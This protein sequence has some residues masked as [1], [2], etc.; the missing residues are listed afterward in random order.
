M[1][2]VHIPVTLAP[3]IDWPMSGVCC[4]LC[5]GCEANDSI[6][7]AALGAKLPG[8]AVMLQASGSFFAYEPILKALQSNQNMPLADFIASPNPFSEPAQRP[9]AEGPAGTSLLKGLFHQGSKLF[10]KD[11]GGVLFVTLAALA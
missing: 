3:A 10:G 2:H 4:R 7:M 1:L 11:P 9:D 5:Q 6:L 8:K